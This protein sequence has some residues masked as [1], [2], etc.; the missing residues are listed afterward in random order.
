MYTRNRA[1]NSWSHAVT[2]LSWNSDSHK[3]SY[4]DLFSELWFY[5]HFTISCVSLLKWLAC[6]PNFALLNRKKKLFSAPTRSDKIVI[7]VSCDRNDLNELSF[8]L[9]NY[10]FRIIHQKI[11]SLSLYP[12]IWEF[13]S[14][15]VM[16]ML[17]IKCVLICFWDLTAN[18][19][20][21]ETF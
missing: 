9:S 10:W 17:L 12:F 14:Y 3:L 7:C 8:F 18:D 16:P 11:A 21:S 13:P 4:Y 15:T 6:N 20:T 1:S 5:T 2:K 19:L